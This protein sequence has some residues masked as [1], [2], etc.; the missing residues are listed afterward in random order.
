[1]RRRR[2]CCELCACCCRCSST[3]NGTFM[4]CRLPLHGSEFVLLSAI[5]LAL[6]CTA[7]YDRRCGELIMG[8]AISLP[9]TSAIFTFILMLCFGETTTHIAGGFVSCA[10]RLLP[11]SCLQHTLYNRQPVFI[12]T[13][14]P[15]RNTQLP[16]LPWCV[17]S[18]AVVCLQH[19]ITSLPHIFYGIMKAK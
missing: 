12:V 3:S 17:C 11:Y 5:R 14:I 6:R 1:M 8:E 15:A 18:A 2:S 16:S 7:W 9:A 10:W 13:G 4:F 19:G